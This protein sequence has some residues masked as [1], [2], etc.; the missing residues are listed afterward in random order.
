M[1]RFAHSYFNQKVTLQQQQ[2]TIKLK[3]IN[4]QFGQF[5]ACFCVV[6]LKMMELYST[7]QHYVICTYI[8]GLNMH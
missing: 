3:P 6:Y 8:C 4:Y 1:T 2:K 7:F 5:L